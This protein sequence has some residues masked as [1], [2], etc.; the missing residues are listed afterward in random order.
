MSDEFA[1]SEPAYQPVWTIDKPWFTIIAY[2]F[3][4]DQPLLPVD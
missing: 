1:K 4:L 3:A 2:W